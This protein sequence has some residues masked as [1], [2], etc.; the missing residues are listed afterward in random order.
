[1]VQ[2]SVQNCRRVSPTVSWHCAPPFARPSP[3]ALLCALLLRLVQLAG[4]WDF[5]VEVPYMFDI[6]DV[7]EENYVL[8]VVNAGSDYK[9]R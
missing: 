7:V 8:D 2:A 6:V 5:V 9:C 3:H 1:M 4:A